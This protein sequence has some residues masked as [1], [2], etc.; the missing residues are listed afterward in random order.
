MTEFNYL[1]FV[2]DVPLCLSGFSARTSTSIFYQ[3]VYYDD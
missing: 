3:V 2:F 1:M